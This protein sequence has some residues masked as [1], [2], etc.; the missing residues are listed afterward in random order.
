MITQYC[1][2]ALLMSDMTFYEATAKA[3]EE[4]ARVLSSNS[5]SFKT[6]HAAEVP[7]PRKVDPVIF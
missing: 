5:M 7:L 6:L 4:F 2:K 3:L 1:Y